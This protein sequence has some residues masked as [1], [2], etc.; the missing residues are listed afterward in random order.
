MPLDIEKEV[1]ALQRLST[2]Q[3]ADRYA[4]L[5]GEPTRARHRTY[6]L[7]KV[8]WKLQALQEGDISERAR[9]RAVELARGTELR[10]MAPRAND[11][12]ALVRVAAGDPRLPP[13]G[14]AIIRQYKG[15][16]IQVVVQSDGFEFEGELYKSLTAVAKKVTGTH[17][18]GFRFFDLEDKS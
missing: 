5:Y 1:A 7:R 9:K 8:A 16:K 2:I 12:P 17:C 15:N 4:E 10:V 13:V 11:A 6:L 18:N 3:L 14:T